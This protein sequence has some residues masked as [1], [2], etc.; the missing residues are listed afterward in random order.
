MRGRRDTN[1]VH[2]NDVRAWAEGCRYGTAPMADI[3]LM[4][5]EGHSPTIDK[6]F[7]PTEDTSKR[8][9]AP[10]VVSGSRQRYDLAE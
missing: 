1:S 8:Q 6:R 7:V 10:I 3:P 2:D 9:D 4:K 5:V